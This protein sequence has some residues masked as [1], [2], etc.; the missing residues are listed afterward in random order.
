MYGMCIYILNTT[1]VSKCC[2][3]SI[4]MSSWGVHRTCVAL[5]VFI[6]FDLSLPTE[7][8]R[9]WWSVVAINDYA[10]TINSNLLHLI[11]TTHHQS[12]RISFKFDESLGREL[13]RSG[14][15]R[16]LYEWKLSKIT[17]FFFF[18]LVKFFCFADR[19]KK[20]FFLWKLL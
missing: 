18:L 17:K 2:T 15:K 10:D 8:L 6:Q 9:H 7:I 5:K 11:F 1:P 16:G 3:C 13:S 20:F 19:F 4:Q 14:Q 12:L